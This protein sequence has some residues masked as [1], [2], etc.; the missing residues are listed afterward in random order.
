MKNLF[1]KL[2]II[3]IVKKIEKKKYLQRK[4]IDEELDNE[5]L[6]SILFSRLDAKL[7]DQEFRKS[8]QKKIQMKKKKKRNQVSRFQ[9][10]PPKPNR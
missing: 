4:L 3:I 8:Q 9:K 7:N 10:K 6:R 1:K 5:C 2:Q